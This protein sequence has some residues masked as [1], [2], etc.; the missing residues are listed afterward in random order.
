MV[1][2]EECRP[3]TKS[4]GTIVDNKRT[5]GSSNRH[6][7]PP[8]QVGCVCMTITYVN[9]NE[10]TGSENWASTSIA[11]SSRNGAQ[12]VGFSKKKIQPNPLISN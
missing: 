6:C 2:L 1:T 11:T 9:R 7:A 3:T 12:E 5:K 10:N 8:S 4:S